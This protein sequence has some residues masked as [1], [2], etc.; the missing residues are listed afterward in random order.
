MRYKRSCSLFLGGNDSYQL[1]A[2]GEGTAVTTE[3]LAGDLD[4]VLFLL[5]DTGSNHLDH[6]TLVGGEASDLTDNFAHG[7]NSGV[8]LSIAV[9]LLHFLSIGVTLDLCNDE[10]GIETDSDTTLIQLLHHLVTL[11]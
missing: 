3:S 10:A 8:E 6:L 7:F 11:K 1:V 4:G 9:G 2:L 5:F